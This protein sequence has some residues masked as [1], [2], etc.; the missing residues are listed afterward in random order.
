LVFNG[1][2]IGMQHHAR[3]EE[4]VLFPYVKSLE[5][6][7]TEVSPLCGGISNPISVLESEHEEAGAALEQLRVLTAGYAVPDGACGTY[8][9]MLSALEELEMDTHRHVHKENSILFPRAAQREAELTA[10]TGTC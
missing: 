2:R 9:A 6:A 5:S 7:G 3:K 10:S 4:N 8:I 1:F